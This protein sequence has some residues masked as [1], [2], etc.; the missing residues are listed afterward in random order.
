MTDRRSERELTSR[1]RELYRMALARTDISEART[2]CDLFLDNVKTYSD[3]LY[4]ILYAAIVV[5]YARPFIQ[6]RTL[7]VLPSRW[8]KFSDPRL[9]GTHNTL[10]SAR[11][12][13]VAHS[14]VSK[15]PATV[16]PPGS[17]VG[18]IREP[19]ESFGIAVNSYIF[20]PTSFADVHDTCTD[21]LNRLHTEIQNELEELYGQA[22]LKGPIELKF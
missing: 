17:T 13:I 1:K 5:A 16:Y 4:R 22:N 7:G 20:R 10:I 3:P 8:T 6:S 9:Q 12:E 18:P 2:A 19:S 11:N 14:D 15:R 21:L